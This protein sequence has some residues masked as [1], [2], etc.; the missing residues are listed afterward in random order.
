MKE[1]RRGNCAALQRRTSLPLL[2][3]KQTLLSEARRSVSPTAPSSLSLRPTPPPTVTSGV[4]D[5]TE[6]V[7]SSLHL[8]GQRRVIFGG[9]EEIVKENMEVGCFLTNVKGGER[10]REKT[11]EAGRRGKTTEDWRRN[12]PDSPRINRKKG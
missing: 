6:G 5:V 4:H 9:G 1:V 12:L 3:V 10:E 7:R 11:L 8:S 2:R